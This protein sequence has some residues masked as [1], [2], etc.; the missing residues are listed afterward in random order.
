MH[1]MNISYMASMGPRHDW[2]GDV[3]QTQS[4]PDYYALQWGHAMIGVET[5]GSSGIPRP[6]PGLQWGHAMIGVETRSAPRRRT[7]PGRASMGP[8]HDWRGDV[9]PPVHETAE[10]RLQWGH[11]MIG[12]ETRPV[13]WGGP[14]LGCFNGATP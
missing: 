9:S 8:R 10:D 6:P 12:V 11:A 3:I 7:A 4:S 2:R 13:G 1:Y 5:K 14:C